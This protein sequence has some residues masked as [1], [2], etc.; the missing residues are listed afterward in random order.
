[1]VPKNP[2]GMDANSP[3]G[4]LSSCCIRKRSNNRYAA[5]R[6]FKSLNGG[7]LAFMLM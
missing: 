3:V 7:P 6:A 1:M 5:L 4:K 2:V